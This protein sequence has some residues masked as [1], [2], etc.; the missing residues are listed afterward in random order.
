[1]YCES[2]KPRIALSKKTNEKFFLILTKKNKYNYPRLGLIVAKKNVKLAVKRNR[3]KR[4]VR[5]SFRN[6]KDLIK[7]IDIVFIAKPGIDKLSSKE[8]RNKIE[9]QWEKLQKYYNTQ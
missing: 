2:L 5:E 4:I 7:N 8:L 1:M 6:N 9:N 3:I